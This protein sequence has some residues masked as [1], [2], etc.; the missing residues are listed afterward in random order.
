MTPFY[1][2][3]LLPGLSTAFLQTVLRRSYNSVRKYKA[4]ARQAAADDPSIERGVGELMASLSTNDGLAMAR[5][6]GNCQLPFWSRIAIADFVKAGFS[7]SSIASAF[8][9]SPRT[10]SNVIRSTDFC[11][12]DRVLAAQQLNPPGKFRP[13]IGGAAPLE[14]MKMGVSPGYTASSRLRRDSQTP[15]S[16]IDPTGGGNLQPGLTNNSSNKETTRG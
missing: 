11:Q 2:S 1:I 6:R 8:K 13:R 10:I 3:I 15:T 14:P 7:L 5:M 4:Q 16:A 12:I 9:C